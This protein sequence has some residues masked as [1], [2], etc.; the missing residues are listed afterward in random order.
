MPIQ[1]KCANCRRDILLP[2]SAAGGR[3]SCPLCGI[4][5]FV[6]RAK[7][8]DDDFGLAPADDE[9]DK[10]AAKAEAENREL[11]LMLRSDEGG[12]P[13]EKPPTPPG[14]GPAAEM[15]EFEIEN[16]VIDWLTAAVQGEDAKAAGLLNR[17]KGRGLVV[18]KILDTLDVSLLADSPLSDMP[19]PVLKRFKAQL[20][21]SLG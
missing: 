20:L 13:A 15:E 3:S 9:F 17:L 2:D 18:R 5:V 4:M 14:A 11:E 6:P 1:F 19:P 8:A 16:A 21:G 7:A 10:A 12:A